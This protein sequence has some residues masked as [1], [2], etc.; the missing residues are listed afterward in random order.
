M[1]RSALLAAVVFA[2]ICAGVGVAAVTLRSPQIATDPET[3]C[4]SPPTG[5]QML[6]LDSTDPWTEEQL[7]G[8]RAEIKRIAASLRTGEKF[9]VFEIPAI[10]PTIP[11]PK[12]AMCSPG[13]GSDADRL[14]QGPRVLRERFEKKFMAPLD[15]YVATLTGLHSAPTTPLLEVLSAISER[16]DFKNAP[17]R[18]RIHVG[19]DMLQNYSG[20]SHYRLNLGDYSAFAKTMQGKELAPNLARVEVRVLYLIR[21]GATAFQGKRH[22]R[23]YR[24]YVETAGGTLIGVEPL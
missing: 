10:A 7:S 1:N 9:S 5:H 3:L 23:W 6:V 15:A 19:S 24:E 21:P 17:G 14:T 13:N 16:D 11:K 18:R 2:L 22:I 12:F 8:L 20:L 4:P